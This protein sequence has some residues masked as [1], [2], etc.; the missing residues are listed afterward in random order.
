M[1]Y[2]KYISE[3]KEN[4]KKMSDILIYVPEKYRNEK[5]PYFDEDICFFSKLHLHPIDKEWEHYWKLSKIPKN[6]EIGKT[7]VMFT[8]GK[9]VIAR[10]IIIDVDDESIFF[11]SLEQV[12]LPQPKKAPTRGFTYVNNS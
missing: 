12:K 1:Q 11:K 10:G 9:F 7:K 3:L 5:S 2:N 8:N 4:D 6:I